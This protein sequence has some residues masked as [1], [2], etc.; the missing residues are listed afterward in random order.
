M[1]IA[2]AG[3]FTTRVPSITG[4]RLTD[5]RTAFGRLATWQAAAEITLDNP[6]FGAGLGNYSEYFDTSHY[7]ADEAPEEVL[8]TR[9]V[10]SPHSNLLWISSELGLT[11]LALYIAANIYLLLMGWRALKNADD[12]RRRITA[13]CFLALV[14]AYWIPGLTLSIGYYS[15]LNLC[16]FFLVGAL[17]SSFVSS[18]KALPPTRSMVSDFED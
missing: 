5:P 15:D 1:L 2:L 3:W 8:D 13:S 17:S 11:G 14:F 18:R 16:F 12:R 4:S 7:Y 10:D 9:A 6:V